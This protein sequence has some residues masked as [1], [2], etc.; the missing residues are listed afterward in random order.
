MQVLTRFD[1]LLLLTMFG[2]FLLYIYK[3]IRSD[4]VEQKM[5]RKD[6]SGIRIWVLVIVSLAGLVIGG[7]L[8]IDNAV[9]LAV[10]AGVSEH[11]IGLTLIAAGTSLP[12]LAASV[13]AAVIKSSLFV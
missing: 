5:P 6:Y 3:Q 8:V 13:A 12:E 7:R 11:V 2:I 9:Y 1:G 4:K 10:H